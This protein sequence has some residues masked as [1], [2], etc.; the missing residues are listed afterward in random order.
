M[1]EINSP[2]LE[3]NGYDLSI[4]FIRA[5]FGSAMLPFIAS[6]FSE[7]YSPHNLSTSINSNTI[8]TVRPDVVIYEY[9]ERGDLD[10]MM[11]FE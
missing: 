2:V 7:V 5:S 3:W 1:E 8:D 6:E 4:M 9:A 11:M 10:Y